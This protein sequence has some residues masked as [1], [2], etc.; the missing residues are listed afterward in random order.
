MQEEG[1]CV[2]GGREGGE[3]RGPKNRSS[4]RA[5]EYAYIMSIGKLL[6]H[7]DEFLLS[8]CAFSFKIAPAQE[9]NRSGSCP[10]ARPSRCPRRRHIALLC[11][12]CA[13][14]DVGVPCAG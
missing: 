4:A 8:F 6:W 13:H 11:T 10:C 14:A 1:K 2:A 3:L 7:L 9:A 5:L 12:V